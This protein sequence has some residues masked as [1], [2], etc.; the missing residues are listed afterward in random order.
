MSR[1]KKFR[2]KLEGS[3]VAWF[4]SILEHRYRRKTAL[5]AEASG[6]RLG[7]LWYRVSKK[8]RTIADRN[9]QLAMPELDEQE[10][11]RIIVG[12]FEHFGRVA[13][14]FLRSMARTQQEVLESVEVVGMENG[15]EAL[16]LGKGILAVTAHF[17][18]WERLAHWFSATGGK[19]TVVAR[20]ANDSGLN[21]QVRRIRANAGIEVLSRGRSTR[22]LV[23]KLRNKEILGLLPDQNSEEAF[24]PFF[25][26]PCGTVL[27]PAKLHRLTGAPLL[28]AYCPRVGPAKYKL[29]IGKMIIPGESES[30]EEVMTRVNASLEEIVRQYPDQWLWIHDRWKS[31]RSRGLV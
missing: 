31:A 5:E 1:A 11:H 4:F 3:L 15:E 18:N 30:N 13:G 10:R 24:L 12:V 28:P 9:L 21:Q 25:G 17:G 23:T 2:K 6:V 14:D 20:D 8:H 27:G 19:I 16:A 22:T 29:I 26:K 7:R